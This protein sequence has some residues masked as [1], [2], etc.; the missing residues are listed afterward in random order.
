MKKILKIIVISFL[1]IIALAL[2]F[3]LTLQVFEYQPAEIIPLTIENNEEMDSTKLVQL[4]TLMK[5][6]TFNIGYASLSETEDFAMDGG[7][8]GRMDSKDGVLANLSGIGNLIISENADIY[9]IQE[10]DEG[11]DRSYQTLQFSYL[12]NILPFS[13]T[14]GYNYRVLFVPFPFEFSQMMGK[15]N[16]GI[17]S[18]INYQV[19]SST[20]VQLPGEFSWPLRLANLKRCIVVNR[21]NIEGSTKQLIVINVHLSAY[22]DGNMRL[23]ELAKLQEIMLAEYNAGNYVV[24]GGDFNQTFPGA[25]TITG[26]D[27]AGK[28]IYEYSPFELKNP[29]F[30]QAYGMDNT[31]FQTNGFQFGVETPFT[32]PTCRLLHQP[33]DK[34]NPA[35][36]QYYVIDGFIV[37]PNVEIISTRVVNA[38]FEFSDHNPVVM[39]FKLTP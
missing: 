24:V 39:E 8:K 7:T 2:T 34:L 36:N 14:L 22:D 6:M 19:A 10:V 12:K 37:S 25:Y 17:V 1:S 33:Y 18:L 20:R 16:S 3:V 5:I 35:N 15:V 28:S 31:W 23:Q 26:E 38:N 32:N 11:S 27:E 21:L 30:W 29:S 13:A 9:L 4:D